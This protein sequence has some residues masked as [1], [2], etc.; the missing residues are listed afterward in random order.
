[1]SIKAVCIDDKNK[2]SEIPENKWIKKNEEY[3][4]IHVTVHTNQNSIQG[5]TLAEITLDGSCAPYEAYKLKRF[6]IRLTD[7]QELIDLML[8]CTEL[9]EVDIRELIEEEVGELV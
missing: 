1:M 7:L 2:P 5:V 3:T 6:A 9:N 4:I 8:N